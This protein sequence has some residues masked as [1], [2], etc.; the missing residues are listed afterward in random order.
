[1]TYFADMVSETASNPGAG[2]VTLTG[3]N[4]GN[5]IGART[6]ASALGATS[7]RV[8]IRIYDAAGAWEVTKATFNG[9]TTLVRDGFRSSSTGSL[10]TFTTTVFVDLV[11]TAE[12]L[13]NANIGM[14]LAQITGQ[15]MP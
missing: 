9:T 4:T 5:I 13:D 12:Q 1:M 6:F 10:I 8:S 2:N 7:Q 14:Q 11:A 3:A 15:A